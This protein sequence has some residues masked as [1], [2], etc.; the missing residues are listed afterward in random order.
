MNNLI[1][2]S[3]LA[4]GMAFGV[5]VLSA[6]PAVAQTHSKPSQIVVVQ[7]GS[8]PEPASLR[9]NSL[10]V[11][12]GND[13]RTYLYIEQNDG[14][15]ISVFDVTD[16]AKITLVVSTQIPDQG[17]FDFVRP[18]GGNTELV[19]YR[20]GQ[21]FGVLD[22]HKASRPAVRA[23]GTSIDFA[24]ATRLG[25]EGLLASP[26]MAH[27]V[28]L[29]TPA[30]VQVVN[31]SSAAPSTLFT[32]KGVDHRAVNDVTGTTFLLGIDGLTVIRQLRVEADY[33]VRQASMAN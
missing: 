32:V 29:V 26:G 33:K 17:A 22:L 4:V 5:A 20:D 11:H 23:L 24:S 27:N 28:A 8:L 31:L 15:R 30:D 6:V 7:P 19:A 25:S 1:Q 9:G 13:G 3:V 2:S 18:M 10:F 12:Y 21:H 16:P 14:A